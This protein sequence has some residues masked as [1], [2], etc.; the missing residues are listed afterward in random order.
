MLLGDLLWIL[1]L[2]GPLW[3]LLLVEVHVSPCLPVR[4][5]RGL[6]TVPCRAGFAS[7]KLRA[8]VGHPTRAI[9]HQRLGLGAPVAAG[10]MRR[11]SNLQRP[12]KHLRGGCILLQ[13]I[14]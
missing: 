7:A 1:L 3:G 10:A 4:G 11:V 9:A 12:A 5:V 13:I 2:G 8:Q 6:H 14:V